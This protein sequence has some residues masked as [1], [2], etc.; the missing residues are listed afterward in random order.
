M[1]QKST[2][3]LQGF[4]DDR[5]PPRPGSQAFPGP[6]PHFGRSPRVVDDPTHFFQKITIG[7]R[8]EENAVF[9]IGNDFFMGFDI[10]DKAAQSMAFRF[11]QGDGISLKPGRENKRQGMAQELL[12][13]FAADIAGENNLR[14]V[15]GRIV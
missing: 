13:L 1:S 11:E 9:L 8:A 14:V 6:P 4:F 12:F 10:A 15:F 3:D 5:V 2:I 7:V